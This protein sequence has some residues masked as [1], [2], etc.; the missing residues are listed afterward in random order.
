VS[1]STEAEKTVRAMLGAW[2]RR[3]AGAAGADFEK[4][5]AIASVTDR[6]A[7][8]AFLRVL[9]DVR[10]DPVEKMLPYRE[11]A[12]PYPVAAPTA[13]ASLPSGLRV[14]FLE[15]EATL[16][17]A[18]SGEPIPCNRCSGEGQGDACQTCKG[19]KTAACS[20]CAQRGRKSC[21]NC[22][23]KGSLVCSQCA[24]AGKVLQSLAGDGMRVEDVCPQCTGK[25]VL[26]C[27]DCADASIPDCAVCGNKRVVACAACA[28]RGSAACAQCGGAR[29]V[30]RGFTAKVAYTIAYY[31]GLLRD[32]RIPDEAFPED[33]SAGKLGET[34]FEWEG[35]D[36]AALAAKKPQGAAGT[37]FD[38]VL[39]LVPAEGPAPNSKRILQVLTIERIP[40]YEAAFTF[41]GKE[42]VAWATSFENR[43]S[44][45][46]DPFADLA[47]RWADAA[48]AALDRNDFAAFEELAAKA[49]ALGPNRPAVAALRGKA[50]QAQ[51]RGLIAFGA[52]AAAGLAVAAPAVLAFV[53]HSPNRWTPLAALGV[54]VLGAALAAVF[55][56]GAA[57]AARPL[58]TPAGRKRWAVGAAIAGAAFAVAA[59][60]AVGPI[61]RLDAREFAAKNAR[62]DGLPFAEWSSADDDALADLIKDYAA[63]GVDVSAG[64]DLAERRAAFVELAKAKAIADAEAARLKAQAEAAAAARK[65]LA[66]KRLAAEIAA[67][68]AAEKKAASKKTKGKGKKKRKAPV[69][70]GD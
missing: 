33:P 41:E 18:E 34:V 12:P 5:I 24:G 11:G 40:V 68:K 27:Q 29:R 31:R 23:G 13:V 32:P 51:R 26:S 49:E 37:A 36:A 64:K 60:A 38:K 28:G 19:A 45:S 21:P 54:L 10:T 6:T 50:G 57:F 55:G 44:L 62:L 47:V 43:V 14:Q 56:A 48:E 20:A 61:V 16:S 58:L 17:A 8:A 22:H 1:E 4:K 25:K 7:H 9:F 65:A 66:A 42:Y 53:Y 2:A 46:H 35:S 70:I 67:E 52:K 15:Q 30:L 63:R 69:H 39:G 3:V 59:F